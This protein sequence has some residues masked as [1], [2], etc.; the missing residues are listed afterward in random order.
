MKLGCVHFSA[1]MHQDLTQQIDARLFGRIGTVRMVD[2]GKYLTVG[3][4][5]RIHRKWILPESDCPK[6]EIWC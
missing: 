2:A 5:D 6:P 4:E 3:V 1:N